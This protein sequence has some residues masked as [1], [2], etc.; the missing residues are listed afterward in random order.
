MLTT[1]SEQ[2]KNLSN[3]AADGS[4]HD[5]HQDIQLIDG[6]DNFFMKELMP[7]VFWNL[8]LDPYFEPIVFN[9]VTILKR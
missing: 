9:M 7:L 6:V 3:L 8:G 1:S 2:Y 4:S 5:S